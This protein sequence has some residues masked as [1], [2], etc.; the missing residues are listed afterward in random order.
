MEV[1]SCTK[2]LHSQQLKSLYVGRYTSDVKESLSFNRDVDCVYFKAYQYVLTVEIFFF[3]LQQ[4][5]AGVLC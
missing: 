3:N 2:G 5:I 4:I 1:Q